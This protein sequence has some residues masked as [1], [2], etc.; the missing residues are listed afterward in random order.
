MTDPTREGKPLRTDSSALRSG[1]STSDAANERH[2]C[3]G[4]AYPEGM[5]CNLLKWSASQSG[6]SMQE[7][8]VLV[9]LASRAVGGKATV[10]KADLAAQFKC[11]DRHISDVL[12]KLEQNLSAHFERA[13]EGA[14]GRGRAA[15]SY[16]ITPALNGTP[17]P[18]SDATSVNS[19]SGTG[20]LV[21]ESN[22]NPASGKSALHG[23]LVPE[24]EFREVVEKSPPNNNNNKPPLEIYPERAV[25]AEP[26]VV[27][28]A[29]SDR[30]PPPV[31]QQLADEIRSP[32]LDPNKSQSLVMSGGVVANWIAAGADY[33]RDIVPTV[34]R[35]M[36]GKASK[37][38]HIRA[39]G[40]FTDAVREAAAARLASEQPMQIITPEFANDQQP[41]GHDQ[42]PGVRRRAR[43]PITEYA[44]RQINQR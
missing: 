38:Q 43:S 28:A 2:A 36:A 1:E 41:S 8:A 18:V 11:S 21:T 19:G 37:G 44:M 6:L 23:S 17:L 24:A 15:N 16:T 40:Y 33:E 32:F 31:W 14:K 35:I 26:V 3:E 9:A 30:P 4:A 22:R 25:L 39:W 34:R 5:D 42:H 10:S 20:V 29:N 12:A 13:R 7:Y 27:V